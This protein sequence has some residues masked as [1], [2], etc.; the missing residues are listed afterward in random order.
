VSSA[1][2]LELRCPAGSVVGS[3]DALTIRVPAESLGQRE[4]NVGG[5][6]SGRC[7]A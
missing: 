7:A 6:R 5:R 2:A 3:A 1:F 4:R